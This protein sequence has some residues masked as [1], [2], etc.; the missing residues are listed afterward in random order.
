MSILIAALSLGGL[1]LLF[2]L[3]LS[4]F[5]KRFTV[6]VDPRLEQLLALL[7]GSN[8]GAC[9]QAGCLGLAEAV[10]AGKKEA[11]GCVAGGPAT[12]TRV[13]EYL[14]VTI[15]AKEQMVAYVACRAGRTTA[16][17]K[18]QYE[19][20]DNCQAVSLL[21]GGDKLCSYGCVGLGSC[22]RVC[23]FDAIHVT[24]EG[25][26]LVDRD[27]CTGCTKCV[28]SC[29]RSVISMVPKRQTVLVGCNNHDRGRRA[30]EVCDLAC[31]ACKICEKNCPVAAIVVTDNLA[32]ID[33]DKCTECGVC[34]EKCPQ[35]TIQLRAETREP[36]VAAT[37]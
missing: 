31:T 29:P 12:A 24:E 6:V 21:F 8:C 4:Y 2:S 7:P 27:K 5:N 1:G 19:G 25:V 15:E 30:K 35:S 32:V 14:G 33:Y 10:L 9:G 23:P 34:V 11:D 26:A 22:V 37:R 3:L 13:A 17:M 28:A 18:Y 16:K 20:V 36:V